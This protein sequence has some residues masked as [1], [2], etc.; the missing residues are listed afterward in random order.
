MEQP[1]RRA[2]LDLAPPAERVGA[3]IGRYKLLE[4]IGEG[5][6]GVVFLAEQQHPVRRK[7]A[8]KVIKPGLDTRQVIARFEAERQALAMMDHP[9]IAKV[10]DAGATDSGRPYVVMELVRGVPV[11]DY[12]DANTLNMRERLELFV[13][14]CNAVQHA[15][16]KGVI[17]RDLKPGNVLVTTHDPRA[18][19]VPKVIDFGVAKATD[20][21]LTERTL[22]T[23]LRQMVGTPAYMSPEQAEMGR[24]LDVDTRSDVYSLGV[25]LYELLTGTPPFDPGELRSKAYGEIQRIIRE[26]E[27]PRPSTRLS[28]LGQTLDAVAARRRTDPARLGRL[29]RGELD[30]VVMKCLEKDRA[31]RY[32]TA[33]ALAADVERYLRDEPV[34]ASPPRA[35]YRLRKFVRRNRGR[36]AAAALVLAALL[37]GT[38][39]TTWGMIRAEYARRDAVSA[40]S[41]EARRAQG[42]RAAREEAQTRLAQVEKGNEILA[43]VFRDVDPTASQTAG[44]TLRDLLCRRLGDA[45]RQLEGD[46]VG[47]PLVVARLQHALGISLRKLGEMEQA[48]VVFVKAWRTR[49][50]LLGADHVDTAAAKHDLALLYK[51]QGK[52]PLAEALYKEVLASRTA[53][54]GLDEPDTLAVRHDLAV[55]YHSQGRYAL[56]EA[57]LT[58][59]LA[60]RTEKLGPNHPDTLTSRHRLAL[61]YKSQRKFA[62]AEAL[63]KEVLAARTARLGA[64]HLDTVATKEM[65]AVMYQARG[66]YALAEA[67]HKEVLV[68]QTAKLGADHPDTLTSR[69]HLAE[70]YHAQGNFPL[71]EAH[72]KELL[73][74]V[75]AR[76]AADHPQALSIGDDLAILY[77]DRGQYDLA[78]AQYKQVL[79]ARTAKQGADHPATLYCQHRLSL[80]YRSMNRPDEAIALMEETVKRAKAAGHPA[81]LG[82]QAGLGAAYC[83]ARR[84]ADAVPVLEDVYRRATA[85]DL[86]VAE[87]GKVL[88]TAYVGA[89]K[90]A[91]ARALATEQARTARQQ[92]PSGSPELAA[93]LA[94]PGQALMEVGAY[95]DAEPLLLDNYKGLRQAADEVHPPPKDRDQQVLLRDAV[96]RLVQ[97]YDGWG[98]PDEAAKWRK[99]FEAA[100]AAGAAEKRSGP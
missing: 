100:H 45:A 18:P 33:D 83:D 71:A 12:C 19:G 89:G 23:D 26:V 49:E 32:G 39:G 10:L 24:G 11:T 46:A 55:L 73:A 5:G 98:K 42:E 1:A 15:H 59:V 69:H 72:Y 78:E 37:V 9:N 68:V 57:L 81:A 80:L 25:L 4:R 87:V 54:L 94:A 29:V 61:A 91:E 27:P 30:W 35:A 53:R 31:R 90:T 28:A 96:A 20:Q 56:A 3:I 52:Y 48:E 47:D 66:Q 34:E 43:S 60:A 95:A 92:F 75:T 40:R 13:S 99:E 88:L 17:H 79:A 65:L 67:L 58:E 74:A 76:F 64:D 70:S 82:M 97:L 7:V 77:R 44:M 38:A 51:D 86:D 2:A 22:F 85:G 62:Q 63:Y 14:V 21:R 93:A 6:F 84:F 16:S 8:L 50:R 41:A 36:V